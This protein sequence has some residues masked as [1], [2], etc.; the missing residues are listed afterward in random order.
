M[1][2]L[3]GRE[4]LLLSLQKKPVDRVAF[5]PLIEGYFTS[6][7]PAPKPDYQVCKE[8]GCEILARHVPVLSS[9]IPG[10]FAWSVITDA[11]PEVGFEIKAVD[12]EILVEYK[13]R[14]HRLRQRLKFNKE[15]PYIPWVTEFLV[16]NSED[17]KVFAEIYSRAKVLHEPKTFLDYDALC[18]E[19]GMATAS[20]PASPL[21]VLV[22]IYAGLENTV[23]LLADAR[24]EFEEF[25]QIM[26]EKNLE[27]CRVIAES[28]AK[29]VI[30]YENTSSSTTG[31]RYFQKYE[32]PCIN[33]YT[34]IFKAAGKIHLIHMCG[35]L[36]N[37]PLS[38]LDADG[39]VDISPPPPGNITPAE[40]RKAWPGKVL[41]GGIDPI[42]Y[43]KGDQGQLEALVRQILESM[44]EDRLGF[45]L[46]SAD[47]TPKGTTLET[48]SFISRMVRELGQ[49]S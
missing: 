5:A 16:K 23:F 12:G 38:M 8:C 31:P 2:E 13:L 39:F 22:N 14:G 32:A 11:N 9:D 25:N 28:P 40:A 1:P 37:M 33:D 17:L 20:A 36:K 29:V 44:A 18:A 30:S 4:R 43:L 49:R 46:G 45:I 15:S 26:H 6:G 19:Q 21:Q 7:L 3:S 47:A 35:K 42:S 41:L 24:N 34:G 27:V 48:L 10:L